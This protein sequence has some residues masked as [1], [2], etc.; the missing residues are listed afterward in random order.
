MTILE[1]YCKA[2]A[3]DGKEITTDQKDLINQAVNRLVIGIALFYL[4]LL[5]RLAMWKS[6]L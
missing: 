2:V 4:L 3:T 6:I 5:G 1:S